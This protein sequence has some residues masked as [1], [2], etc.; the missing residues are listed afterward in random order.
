MKRRDQMLI[1]SVVITIILSFLPITEAGA[2]TSDYELISVTGIWTAANGGGDSVTGIGTNLVSWGRTTGYGKSGLEFSGSS[3]QQFNEGEY[4]LLGQLTHLNWPVFQPTA[5]GATLE[6]TLDFAHPDISPI[7][8]FSFD[9]EVEETPNLTG[10]CPDWHTPGALICDD[11]ITFPQSYGEEVFLIGD[12]QY[13]L[14]IIGFVDTFP[15]GIPVEKFITHEKENNTV[16][17]VG[18]LSSVLVEEPAISI[19]KKTNGQDIF[20]SPGPELVVGENVTWQ[21]IVQNTGNIDLTNVSIIDD[22]IGAITCPNTSLDAGDLM[23]CTASGTVTAGQ[24]HNTAS[25]TAHSATG[26]VTDEDSSWYY[27]IDASIDVE[28]LVWNG[29]TW[30]DADSGTGPFLLDDGDPLFKFVVTN[31]GETTLE[32]VVLSDNSIRTLYEDQ[33]LDTACVESDPFGPG[34]SF[35]CY[36]EMVWTAGQHE[37]LASVSGDYKDISVED[38]D[39]AHYFGATL[40]IEIKKEVWDGSVWQDADSSPGPTLPKS[41][42]PL[43]KFTVTNTGNAALNNVQLSDSLISDLY[44]DQAL[45]EDCVE[46]EP[47]VSGTSFTCFGSLSWAAGQHVNTASISG[48][49]QGLRTSDT[50]QAHYFRGSSRISLDKSA[51]PAVFTALDDVITYTFKAKNT[52]DFTLS[53]VTITDPVPGLSAL[54]CNPTQ[55]ATL[56]PGSAMTCTA[57]YMITQEDLDRGFVENTATVQGTDEFNETVEDDNNVFVEGP[58]SGASI[59][60]EKTSDPDIYL[61]V[62]D[63]ITFTFVVTNDGIFTLENVQITDPLQGLGALDCNETLPAVL[64]PDESVNCTA[65]YIIVQ[66]D[67]D[68]GSIENTATATGIASN[69]EEVEDQDS[70]VIEGPKDEASIHL[71]KSADPANYTK[72]GEDIVYSFTVTNNG[73]FTLSDVTVTD[74]LFSLD[75]GPIDELLPG[76][77]ETFK[78]AYIITEDDVEAKIIENTASA[79]GYDP[80]EN[81]VSDSDNETVYGPEPPKVN[82]N[83]VLPA[84][85]FAPGR[86]TELPA[87]TTDKAYTAFSSFRLEISRLGLNL[88]IVG[89]PQTDS[90]W[91]VSWLGDNVGWLNGTAF[92]TWPGN[93]VITGHVWDAFDQAGPFVNI[94]QL[95]YGDQIIIHLY[96]LEYTFEVRSRLTVTPDDL[97]LIDQAEDYAWLNLITCKGFNSSADTYSYRL[98]VRAVL[99]DVE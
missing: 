19:T 71:E 38:S 33:A 21:Y 41:T 51:E 13:T 34:N 78:Y 25:V 67:L 75:F 44:V 96:G 2:Q 56:T 20:A 86:I 32:N 48:E 64:E 80:G 85:G 23:T 68:N 50:D 28:K 82:P 14:R 63:E 16:N 47:L 49:L 12:K 92:P 7:P 93:S 88:D 73:I 54:T 30:M 98:I 24:Y 29:S 3:E 10:K 61:A 15:G 91:D 11:R 26:I 4:F 84:T 79:M 17:L 97:S 43:F 99:V 60:L 87:Q 8:G 27:G 6:I 22:K 81:P 94:N 9:F 95:K 70:A 72:V 42:D 37:N 74:P 39:L 18:L 69:E 5:S 59:D 66:T 35:T 58:K 53:G 31:T 77:S 45:I 52:G 90:G 46:P 1:I 36:G 76:E 83:P 55:P 57:T 40:G 89:V 62:D 65:T